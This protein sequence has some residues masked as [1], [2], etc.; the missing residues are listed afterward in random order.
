MAEPVP[1]DLPVPAV[2]AA[3]GASPAPG[4]R[5]GAADAGGASPGGAA[6]GGMGS[7]MH[8]TATAAAAASATALRVLS[9]QPPGEEHIEA[10]AQ[11][12]RYIHIAESSG[13]GG[14]GPQ[15]RQAQ[16]RGTQPSVHPAQGREAW[17]VCTP[18]RTVTPAVAAGG[19]G[20]AGGPSLPPAVL[21]AS[22]SA[23]VQATSRKLYRFLRRTIKQWPLQSSASL[24]P[25]VNLWLNIITPWAAPSS[26]T[27]PPA[28]YPAASGH[29]GAAAAT[30]SVGGDGQ[31]R[32]AWQE[33]VA[34]LGMELSHR[35]AHAVA[36]D[37]AQG[38]GGG[39]SQQGAS[40]GRK[41]RLVHA[42]RE[43]KKDGI[44]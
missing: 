39:S 15:G 14:A 20:P 19:R 9:Y 34:H 7:P 40:N 28:G 36:H 35:L 38:A 18:L 24:V 31:G 12:V 29:G 10:L 26:V 37:G 27:A 43:P 11:L 23:G 3:G 30:G 2:T 25:I 16:G 5:P 32:P 21:G 4:D 17:L 8:S 22:G 13:D 41:V 1:D 6:L 42:A 33:G 44:L